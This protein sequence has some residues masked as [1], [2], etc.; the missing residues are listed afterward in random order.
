MGGL[1]DAL[2]GVSLPDCEDLFVAS[3]GLSPSA[4][5]MSA[6]AED[7]STHAARS[8]A[9][10][11][12]AAGAAPG[13]CWLFDDGLRRSRGDLEARGLAGRLPERR[14]D[15]GLFCRGDSAA[16]GP[17]T[18]AAAL[19]STFNSWALSPTAASDGRGVSELEIICI[20]HQQYHLSRLHKRSLNLDIILSTSMASAKQRQKVGFI[21]RSGHRYGAIG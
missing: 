4:A 11:F 12:P 15:R 1:T 13:D 6:P 9:A 21:E 3:D 7:G 18:C 8:G 17:V 20:P 5:P 16:S 10:I 14:R 2:M 19:G